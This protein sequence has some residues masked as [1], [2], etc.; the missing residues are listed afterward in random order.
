M[1]IAYLNKKYLWHTIKIIYVSP[2]WIVNLAEPYEVQ[3]WSKNFRIN[4]EDLSRAVKF[5]ELLCNPNTL[6]I[7]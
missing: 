2:I 4:I 6:A 1:R 3:D 5:K 7:K